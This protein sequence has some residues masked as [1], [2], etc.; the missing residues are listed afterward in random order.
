MSFIS[1]ISMWMPQ[2]KHVKVDKSSWFTWIFAHSRYLLIQ[3][4]LS[5]SVCLFA[6]LLLVAVFLQTLLV[7]LLVG[8]TAIWQSDC[9]GICEEPE[10]K[11]SCFAMY[12]V[13]NWLSEN[14][15]RKSVVGKQLSEIH[16]PLSIAIWYTYPLIYSKFIK[17]HYFLISRLIGQTYDR[18][19]YIIPKSFE[20]NAF[21]QALR[22]AHGIF[23][24]MKTS[25]L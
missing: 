22:T 5:A 19:G 2:H 4:S 10:L 25:D 13:G 6:L 9:L 11:A 7:S 12:L 15:C 14:G 17:N 20:Q 3:M 1:F 24:W 23:C 21:A 8:V 16:F 18:Q